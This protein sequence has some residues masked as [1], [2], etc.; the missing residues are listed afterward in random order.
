MN[1]KVFYIGL[2]IISILLVTG[3]NYNEKKSDNKNETKTQITNGIDEE[4]K[5]VKV[6]IDNNYYAIDL[7][8]NETVKEFIN[9]LPK[10]FNMT[11]LN[12]NEKYIYLDNVLPTN[13]YNPGYINKGDVML[14]GN[15]CL[16]IFYKSFN[17][18]YSYTKIG[19]INDLPDLDNNNIIVK[20]E[21]N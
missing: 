17:S 10:E 9:I 11:E 18:N 7:E 15:N 14:Y 6:K 8:E 12:G 20:F 16:V 2:I 3:C 1:K 13:E 5:I 4:D 21:N 19:H